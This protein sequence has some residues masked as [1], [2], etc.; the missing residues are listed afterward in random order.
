MATDE[1]VYL[2]PYEEKSFEIK[3]LYNLL[4]VKKY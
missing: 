4:H 3:I 2:V 1:C